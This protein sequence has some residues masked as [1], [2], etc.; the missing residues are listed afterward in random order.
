M[1][2]EIIAVEGKRLPRVIQ[3]ESPYSTSNGKSIEENLEYARKAMWSILVMGDTPY[4]SHLLYTQP[5]VLN[6]AIP[7]ERELGIQAGLE[8]YRQKKSDAC[9]IFVENGITLG[10]LHGIKVALE[11]EIPVEFRSIAFLE[12]EV[13]QEIIDDTFSRIHAMSI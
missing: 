10:M 11:N 5:G 2:N 9:A 8:M 12:P 1:S 4:A 13:F 7:E 6:D 3:V